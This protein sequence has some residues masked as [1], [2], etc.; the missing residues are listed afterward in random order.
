MQIARAQ[1]IHILCRQLAILKCFRLIRKAEESINTENSVS[2]FIVLD[3]L[4]VF[5]ILIC[6]RIFGEYNSSALVF[7]RCASQFSVEYKY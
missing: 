2:K 3:Y 5:F 6:V 4:F 7:T 1:M